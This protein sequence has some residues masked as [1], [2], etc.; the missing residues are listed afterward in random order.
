MQ[1]KQHTLPMKNVSHSLFVFVK[2]SL[3][4]IVDSTL[5]K[6]IT[7]SANEEETTCECPCQ[8]SIN[9]NEQPDFCPKP[10]NLD[11][12]VCAPEVQ[13]PDII[14]Y[15]SRDVLMTSLPLPPCFERDCGRRA[16]KESC[17]GVI[18]CSWCEKEASLVGGK[19]QQ[20]I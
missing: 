6:K 2:S 12:P 16:T 5:L 7:E 8:C 20:V 1:L 18:G 11:E 9:N 17:L 19:T 13:R 15:L 4:H 10:D 3:H 14:S